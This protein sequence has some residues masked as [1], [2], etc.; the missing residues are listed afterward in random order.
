MNFDWKGLSI[1][2]CFV[3]FI[4][5]IAGCNLLNSYSDK[6]IAETK[7][8]KQQGQYDVRVTSSRPFVVIPTDMLETTN[9]RWMLK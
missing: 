8:L 4:C 5:G 6:L 3:L 1:V 2:L 7:A 9:G